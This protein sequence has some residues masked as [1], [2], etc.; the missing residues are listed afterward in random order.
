MGLF[1]KDRPKGGPGNN[2][3]DYLAREFTAGA[4][5]GLKLPAEAPAADD[6]TPTLIMAARLKVRLAASLGEEDLPDWVTTVAQMEVTPEMLGQSPEQTEQ[7]TLRAVPTPGDEEH[8]RGGTL[9]RPSD[10]RVPH[11]DRVHDALS[12]VQEGLAASGGPEPTLHIEVAPNEPVR[13]TVEGDKANIDVG[14]LRTSL[15]YQRPEGVMVYIEEPQVT[16]ETQT[17]S[18][19]VRPQL[20]YGSD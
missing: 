11:H 20:V 1:R 14:Q 16:E 13:V 2:R 19:D 12:A 15:A 7:P 6:V 17:G 3:L 4:Y 5:H 8:V 9:W 18:I 10:P